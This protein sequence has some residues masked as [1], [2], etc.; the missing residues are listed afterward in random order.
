MVI[1]FADKMFMYLKVSH[2]Y[3][4]LKKGTTYK[5]TIKI[6]LGQNE[7]LSL[8]GSISSNPEKS[9]LRR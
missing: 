4:D 1:F 5:L 7:D 2:Q 3:I 8:G 9:A 6:Y